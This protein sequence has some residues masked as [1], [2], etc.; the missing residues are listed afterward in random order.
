MKTNKKQG[1]LRLLRSIDG[2][3]HAY[4]CL[5]CGGSWTVYQSPCCYCGNCLKYLKE[6]KILGSKRNNQITWKLK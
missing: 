2:S 4:E 5:E 1:I 3:L 6:N